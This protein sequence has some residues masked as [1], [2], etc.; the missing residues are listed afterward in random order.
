MTIKTN[1]WKRTLWASPIKRTE[2]RHFLL[3]CGK[4]RIVRT[5][6]QTCARRSIFSRGG[7][8]LCV[9]S[10]MCFWPYYKQCSEMTEHFHKG[11]EVIWCVCVCVPPPLLTNPFM[12]TSSNQNNMFFL[13]KY[14]E[15]LAYDLTRTHNS[16][17]LSKV[18]FI[19]FPGSDSVGVSCALRATHGC[20]LPSS[21][22]LPSSRPRADAL[23]KQR[24]SNGSG[25]VWLHDWWPHLTDFD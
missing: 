18:C 25:D 20:C 3:I 10:P 15:C 9:F 12:V 11:K 19:P 21:P 14:T 22:P 7:E 1:E 17:P 13:V 16:K 8:R 5:A 2:A 6:F 24:T 23:A 4:K